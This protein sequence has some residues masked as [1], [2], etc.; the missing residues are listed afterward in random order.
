MYTVKHNTLML[1]NN[2]LHVSVYQNFHFFLTLVLKVPIDGSDE[3]K[4]VA[5][6]CIALKYC[7]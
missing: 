4:H 6:C 2:V 5:H 3:W 7:V 1:Y